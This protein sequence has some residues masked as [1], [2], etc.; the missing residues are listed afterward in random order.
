MKFHRKITFLF[1]FAVAV[2]VSVATSSRFDRRLASEKSGREPADTLQLIDKN[3]TPETRQ[4]AA[5]MSSLVQKGFMLGQQNATVEGV[6]WQ[7]LNG[8]FCGDVCKVT[9]LHPAVYGWDFNDVF[10]KDES[11]KQMLRDRMIQVHEAGGINEI[12]WHMINPV[13]HGGYKDKTFAC[14]RSL[15]GGDMNAEFLNWLDQFAFFIGKLKDKNGTPIPVIFR[16]WHEANALWFW[17]GLEVC[18]TDHYKELWDTTLHQLR[19][20]D[21]IHQLLWAYSYNWIPGDNA[22]QWPGDDKVDI[23]GIDF[24]FLP[25][26]SAIEPPILK[27]QLKSLIDRAHEKGKIAAVTE[28]GYQS[29]FG[30][31]ELPGKTFWS[32]TFL[33]IL[34]SEEIAHGISYVMFWRN[35][36]KDD[37]FL[38]YPGDVSVTDFNHVVGDPSALFL[39]NISSSDIPQ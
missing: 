35:V 6:G 11:Y 25:L 33:N 29:R 4:L 30:Y 3:A 27:A 26:M 5:R 7:N 34:D 12:S 23:M 8:E 17:W 36:S 21:G 24:Y 18:S 22:L 20:V 28:M 10:E 19:D 13:T 2:A 37:F 1:L 31:R 39:E 16:P 15:S 14:A 32:Q 38:P 9:K